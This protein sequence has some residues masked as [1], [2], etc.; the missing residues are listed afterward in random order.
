[1]MKSTARIGRRVE[2]K[3]SFLQLTL[4]FR[5]RASLLRTYL[6]SQSS[7]HFPKNSGL[8]RKYATEAT[9]TI[10][11]SG[12]VNA[13][14]AE[15]ASLFKTY[16][17]VTP[18]L[19]HLRRPRNDHLYEGRPV[20][21]LTVARRKKGGRNNTGR[22]TV[23]HRGGGHKQ[24]IRIIDFVRKIPGIH[25]VVRIEFDPGRSAHIA[26]LQSRDK[27]A[28]AEKFT[29]IL[30]PD[31]LRAGDQVQSFRAGIPADIAPEFTQLQEQRA[32]EEHDKDTE[33]ATSST[34]TDM[35]L[36]LGLLR[37][38]TV[39]PGNVLPLKFIPAGTLVHN[40]TLKPEG[41]ALLVR[42]A[43]TFGT[44]VAH[45][46]G[47]RYVQVRLQSGEIRKVLQD[48]CATIGSVSNPL[49]QNRNLGKAG[50]SRWLGRRPSVRGVAMNKCLVLLIYTFFDL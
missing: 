28:G 42:S 47:D 9:P 14:I 10:A 6:T 32:V 1:M 13:S 38:I 35:S 36:A 16:K 8:I 46:K 49:W 3:I 45:P 21:E 41:R 15:T 18:G 5:C 25:D 7:S 50:R 31:G 43:G 2:P 37:S 29:Y 26:L 20:R 27:N 40:I 44:I 30:A 23:R 24:R 39:K 22:I 19:R 4:M 34:S 33:N 12:R 11:H 17:P 48:C